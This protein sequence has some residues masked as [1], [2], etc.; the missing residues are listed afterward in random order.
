MPFKNN[1]SLTL[2]SFRLKN[3]SALPTATKPL[4]FL[5]LSTCLI[6]FKITQRLFFSFFSHHC[7]WDGLSSVSWIRE[8]IFN[9]VENFNTTYLCYLFIIPS[10]SHL[11]PS[12]KFQRPKMFTFRHLFWFLDKSHTWNTNVS[13]NRR[14]LESVGKFQLWNLMSRLSLS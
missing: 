2:K 11:E 6:S 1:F 5:Q 7:Y 4:H 9:S 12:V 10:L 3:K 14:D 13:K 8:E